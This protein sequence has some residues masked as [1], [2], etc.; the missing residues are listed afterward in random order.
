MFDVIGEWFDSVRGAKEGS[1]HRGPLLLRGRG[2]SGIQSEMTLP[3]LSYCETLVNNPGS[4]L[5]VKTQAR[6]LSVAPVVADFE[7][8]DVVLPMS[9]VVA[10][11]RKGGRYAACAASVPS[12]RIA[13]GASRVSATVEYCQ[14]ERA[15]SVMRSG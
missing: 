13:R 8:V 11:L 6:V 12:R 5:W 14:S 3:S 7:V 4:G 9:D 1:S 10:D 15:A 2:G